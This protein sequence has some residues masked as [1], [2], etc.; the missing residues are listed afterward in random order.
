M[1]PHCNWDDYCK[2][3]NEI[4]KKKQKS[5]YQQGYGEIGMFVPYR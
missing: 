2:K 5:K 1:K 4:N 3:Q